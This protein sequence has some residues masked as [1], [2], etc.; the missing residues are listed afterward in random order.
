MEIIRGL[1]VAL[2]A[3]CA[4]ALVALPVAA[5]D[6][7]EEVVVTGSYIKHTNQADVP[8][9]I[10]TVGLEDI[11]ANGWTDLE[12]ITET[13]TFNTS[14][15]GRSGLRSGCCGGA[16]GIE[17]RGLGSSSTLVLQN[18]KRVASTSTG[19]AGADMTNI[20]A[21][22]PVIAIDRMET[23]LDGA[24]ALYGSDA[25]A[26][27]VNI[28][29]RKNFE[30]FEVR[31][32]SKSI[33]GSGQWEV[34][35]ITGVRGDRV[36]G[37]FAMGF[38][39]QDPLRNH[40]RT[41]RLIN[42]TSGNGT[43]GTYNLSARPVSS[44]GGD[45]I[46][47]NGRS[48]VNYST[49]YDDAIAGT[50]QFAAG[51]T[52]LG[53]Q[54]SLRIADPHCVEGIVRDFPGGRGPRGESGVTIPGGGQY[55]PQ[56]ANFTFPVGSCRFTYQPSN[57]I[58]PEE[59]NVL[60][61]TNWQVNLAEGQDLEIEYSM[62]WGQVA[63]HFIPSF[64]MTNGRP[65]VPAENPA[66]P[67]G[68]DASWTG[69]PL[70]NAYAGTPVDNRTDA[71]NQSH[72]VAMTHTVELGEV[73][74]A[75]WADSWTF[76]ASGQYSWEH[77][78]ERQRD[79]DLRRVQNA[80]NGYG[81]PNCE[82]RFDGPA[83]A[84]S[85]GESNCFW[86]SPFGAD[87]YNSTFDSTSGFGSA[88]RFDPATQTRVN[89][90]QHEV[91]DVIN[92]FMAESESFNERKLSVFEFIAAGNI[93]SLPAGDVGL[94]V[95]IQRRNQTF[96][97]FDTAFQ[98]TLDQ[99]FLSPAIGGTG[100]RS[101]DAIF[102]ELF[103]PLHERIDVQLAVRKEEYSDN[104]GDSTDP[105][106]GINWRATDWFSIRGSYAT[107]FRAPSLRQVV[108][109]DTSAFVTEVQ[110]PIDPIEFTTG[111]GTFRTILLAKNPNLL[112]EES[113]NWNVGVSFLPEVPWGNGSHEFQLDI[114]YALFEFENRI[115]VKPASLV[116]QEDPCGP[117]VQRDPIN[118]IPGPLL[119]NDP[120][121]N[122]GSGPVGN[123]LIV[124]QSF[125]NSGGTDIAS[126][127]ISTRYAFDYGD[128]Q[129]TL[130]TETSWMLDYEIRINR[131]DPITDG[132]GY[133][134]DG[135]P[136]SPV[137]EFRTNF[138]ATVNYGQH[139]G[140][141]TVR[142]ISEL[143]DDIFGDRSPTASTV[144]SHVEVDLQ[145][146]LNFGNEEQYNVA[147]GVIN[148]F[149]EEPPFSRFEGYVTRVHN[150]FMRQLYARFSMS[151]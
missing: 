120:T 55:T 28:L 62:R 18:G 59:N 125:Q 45:V 142:Y 66:N 151:M 4:T 31:T 52:P 77:T 99:G 36:S 121:G 70:G 126:M 133:T 134:N 30:G 88:F 17:L 69:R 33:D 79:T 92:F 82:I 113:E 109:N 61:Y 123:V 48:T 102:A 12:D 91:Y 1:R 115:Q 56:T 105:K 127:D 24:A 41:F 51:A 138:F 58:T 72:R 22:M 34:Q 87:I 90:T 97:R 60:A 67:W 124:N 140:N 81:G 75:D 150:P 6:E 64:P 128:A 132:V 9:P 85:P 39:H 147:V 145:Y 3:I 73:I 26:G 16:R 116:V 74:D 54:T 14:S 141:M 122:C 35:F 94:A 119:A 144:D 42:N 50:G 8:S 129:I 135:N 10:D 86:W 46:I 2:A 37:M 57:S 149:D 53:A 114:D 130:R 111:T 106:I 11:Q 89:G 40:E 108:G 20:K 101:V 137:P 43:P 84:S 68:V 107:S 78:S 148:A 21:L 38:E 96:E 112:P 118:F 110:D 47:N 25:V 27:V 139:T 104:L 32:G 131:G 98:Q 93:W 80:L 5:E 7:I 136:G 95:G 76:T 83:S 117:A 15:W 49:L 103:V 44:T 71:D 13:F 63:S 29:P 65:V 23:L 19:S 100:N 143:K 146:A